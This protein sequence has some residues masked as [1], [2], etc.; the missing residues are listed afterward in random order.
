MSRLLPAVLAW[1]ERLA[2]RRTERSHARQQAMAAE[3]RRLARD[4]E[5]WL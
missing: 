5:R 3:E 2:A 4:R 1:V